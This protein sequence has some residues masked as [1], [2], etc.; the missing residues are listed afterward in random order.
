MKKIE[1]MKNGNLE[2]EQ[3]DLKYAHITAI[4]DG[5]HLISF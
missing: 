4:R 2:A 5:K 1:E 3:E